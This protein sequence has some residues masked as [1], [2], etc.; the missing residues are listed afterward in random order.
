VEYTGQRAGDVRHS[1]AD[2]S[3]A[4]KQLGYR[5]QVG[6]EDG[7]RRTV[8]WYLKSRPTTPDAGFQP[9]GVEE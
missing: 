1:L 6:F 8:D 5:V 9:A 7:L 3:R 2:L 4:E